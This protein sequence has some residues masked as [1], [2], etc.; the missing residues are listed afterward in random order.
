MKKLF[1]LALVI[2]CDRENALVDGECAQN[3]T[4]VGNAC[5][6]IDGAAGDAS[7][8]TTSDVASDVITSDTTTDTTPSDVTPSDVIV[9]AFQCD[10]GLTLCS[11]TCVDT[12]IDP[13]NCGACSVVCPSLLC[14]NSQCVGSVAGSFVVIGHD[15]GNAYSAAQG[16]V[17]ANSLL[18]TTATSIRVRSYEQ[19]AASGAVANA[20][21]VMNAAAAGAGRTIVY[22]VATQPTDVSTGMTALNTDVLVVYDQSSAPA[23]TLAGIGSGWATSIASFAHVGGVVIVL[24]G[25]GGT[26]PQMPDLIKNAN[27]LDVSADATIAQNTALDVV[28]PS[29]AV[30]IGVVSP[31]GAAKNSV[32]FTCNEANVPP[33]TYVIEDTKNDAG[34]TQPVVVHKVAP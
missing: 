10:D 27:I 7:D 4:L 25:Q 21:A 11:G 5:E 22:T 6:L 33:V 26:T 23:S 12:T 8:A 2:A 9:D 29:D 32:Y 3:Y 20:K 18:L 28:A 19:Y 31:Y 14:A 15:F 1:F 13:F 16:R 24:D 30:G 34:P 17:L